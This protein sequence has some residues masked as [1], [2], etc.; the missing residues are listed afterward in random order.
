M[1]RFS[2]AAIGAVLVAVGVPLVGG[3]AIAAADVTVNNGSGG[4]NS[5]VDPSAT[6]GG[7]RDSTQGGYRD[8]NQG[9]VRTGEGND[10]VRPPAIVASP[11]RG[12]G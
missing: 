7:F 6:Q 4:A 5:Y 8:S 1:T 10:I 3:T 9:E 2:R 11:S 12:A